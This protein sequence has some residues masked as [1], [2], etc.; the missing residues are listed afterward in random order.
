MN[1]GFQFS[2]FTVFL[3]VQTSGSLHVF[4]PFLG[5]FWLFCPSLMLVFVFILALRNL[6]ERQKGVDA[7]GMDCR[8]ELGGEEGGKIVIRIYHMRQHYMSTKERK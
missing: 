7:D 1:Y 4:V 3:S 5:L 8:E 6:F 2:L